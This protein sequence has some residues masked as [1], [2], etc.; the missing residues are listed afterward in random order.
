[1][2]GY[3]ASAGQ[4]EQRERSCARDLCNDLNAGALEVLE[5]LLERSQ[6]GLQPRRDEIDMRVLQFEFARRDFWPD[7]IRQTTRLSANWLGPTS[8]LGLASGAVDRPI[9]AV[10]ALFGRV[11]LAVGAFVAQQSSP[12]RSRLLQTANICS[13]NQF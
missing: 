13:L 2:S 7:A 6:T 8:K 4:E 9:S 1:M 10:G 12:A 11:L 3:T 5:R